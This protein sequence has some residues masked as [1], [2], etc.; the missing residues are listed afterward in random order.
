MSNRF[1][2]LALLSAASALAQTSSLAGRVS[3]SSGAVVPGAA[4]TLKAAGT[5]AEHRVESNQEGYYVVPLLPPGRY[6]VVIAKIGFVTVKQDGMELVVQQQARFDVTLRPGAVSESIEVSARQFVLDTDSATVGQVIGTRQVRDLPLLGRNTYALAMLV[7]GVRASTGVNNLPVD[8]IST[9]A[10]SINGQRASANEFLL[11]GAPNTAASSNQ[12]VVNLNPDAVQEFKVET[13]NFSAEYGRAAG[14]VFNVVSRSG[15]NDVH[16]SLY[17]FLRND[18]LNANDWFANLGGKARPPFKFNQFGGTFGGPVSIP[19]LYGGRNKTFVFANVELVRFIQG[20]TFTGTVPTA[21]QLRGDFGSTRNAAGA[22][23]A[24]Y[25]PAT[26]RANP[27]GAGF[28]RTAFPGNLIP[29]SRFDPVSRNM[30]RFFPAPNAAG[31]AITGVNNYAR[32][33]GNIV[34]KDTISFRVDHNVNDRNRIFFRYSY[35]DTPFLRAS[36]YGPDNVASP[37]IGPQT[38]TRQ[39][40]IIEDTHTFSPTLLATVRY[41]VTRLVNNRKPF[42]FGFDLTTLGLPAYLRDVGGIYT[43]FPAVNITGLGVTGSISNVAGGTALGLTDG[44]DLY[45]TP[46]AAQA[47]LTR[48]FSKHTLKFG[49]EYRAII[50]NNVQ[51]NA[52]DFTFAPQWTQGPNPAQSSA[53]AGN[54]FATFLLGVPSGNLGT[55]PA[56]AQKISYKSLFVQDTFRVTGSLTINMGMRYDLESPRTDRF[57]QLTNFD[58]QAKPPLTAPGLELR[59]ALSFPGVNGL[60]RTNASTDRN[61]FAPRVGL[62][63]RLTPKTLLR[64]GAGIFYAASTGIGTGAAAFGTSGF[65]ATTAVVTSLDGVTPIARFNDP[66]PGGRV[67]PTGSSQGAA[68][69]LGQAVG[70]FDRGAKIPY[71]AQWNFNIQ[72]ELPGSAVLE[73]GYAASR[74]LAQSQNRVWNQLPESALALGDA[75]RQQVNNP[76]FGQIA[77][78][79]LSQR[80]V[81]RAQLL[82]PYPHFDA[83]TAQNASWATSTYHA[84]EAR[85]EKRYSKGFSTLVSYTFSK[86]MDTG[87]GAFS[88]EVLGT[89]GFQNNHNLAAE[90]G[91]SALDQTHR[92]AIN[93]MYEL[94][95]A[96]SAGAAVRALF[97]GWQLGGIWMAFSGGPL[98]VGSQVNNTFSQGGAQRPDWNGVNPALANPGP[99]RWLDSSVF[100][101]P[102]PYKFGNAPRTF[103]GTRS[104]ASRQLDITL[105]KTARIRE[106][107]EL[108]FRSEFFNI[109]NTPRF[110]PP[111]ESFGNPQ[112]GVVSAQTN[113]SRIV[114][115]ALKLSR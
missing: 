89:G 75:L 65:G 17:E 60:P 73:I 28:L 39:N 13:N 99:Q 91:S 12:P 72:R 43:S 63:F 33:D 37:A 100:V 105:S 27:S 22:V 110:A 107:F 49:G 46:H 83:V 86:L 55:V 74:G 82:R 34:N 47:N 48:N 6:D 29:A 70:Y 45:D 14:G 54:G 32:T 103:N 92:I 31:N 97:G 26:T 101:N 62:A 1:L 52:R 115:F 78:G 9:I 69:L 98:G 79:A 38:F 23:I 93:A 76:F 53:A 81:S 108:Q 51:G 67:Q 113:Q 114:Q 77:V 15:T 71:S 85:Y 59:G 58:Y 5:G 7:P 41:S 44:I 16:F 3:D 109:S 25:D 2:G 21:D 19:K 36:P 57:N 18:K 90:W 35:D 20:I 96:K 106:K 112:F 24:M 30:L 87:T 50:F 40:A 11:D 94:P 64:T 95:F 68:T 10:Y 66:L 56:V 111:N 42:S 102:A 8:Q 88:G 104:H 4:I 84:L 61:N 80:T